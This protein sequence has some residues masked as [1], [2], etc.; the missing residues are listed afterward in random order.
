M[1]HYGPGALT[2]EDIVGGE[3][4]IQDF[5]CSY[6]SAPFRF[7]RFRD[8]TKVMEKENGRCD[9]IC[10]MFSFSTGLMGLKSRIIDNVDGDHIWVEVII[11]DEWVPRDISVLKE[12]WPDSFF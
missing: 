11:R 8:I 10:L 7:R 3:N 1:E 6:C 4:E 9:E 2:A 12:K 5:R